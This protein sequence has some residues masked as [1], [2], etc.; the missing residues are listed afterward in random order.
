M[1]P[2]VQMRA[3]AARG[4]SRGRSTNPALSTPRS[5]R[6]S[7]PRTTPRRGGLSASPSPRRPVDAEG[8]ED[9][10]GPSGLQAPVAPGERTRAVKRKRSIQTLLNRQVLEQAE[11]EA[12]LEESQNDEDFNQPEWRI[13]SNRRANVKMMGDMDSK[14]KETLLT[15]IEK[16][17]KA[18]MARFTFAMSSLDQSAAIKIQTVEDDHARRE[19]E[20]KKEL[21]AIAREEKKLRD[22]LNQSKQDYT[23]YHAQDNA[24]IEDMVASIQALEQEDTQ[25]QDEDDEEEEEDEDQALDDNDK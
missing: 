17:V 9:G 19:L 6:T 22:T 11:H 1:N 13:L 7:S 12:K 16:N 4:R 14:R 15:M 18:A 23:V 25:E 5:S 3:P 20:R 21:L 10:A 8:S 2:R 24:V